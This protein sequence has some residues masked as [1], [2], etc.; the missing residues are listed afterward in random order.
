[1][2][3]MNAN[4]E[5]AAKLVLHAAMELLDAANIIEM[6]HLGNATDNAATAMRSQSARMART[7]EK[8][9]SWAGERRSHGQKE[10]RGRL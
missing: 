10:A 7:A 4:I 6:A 1:M 2:R 8:I 9:S 5:A 3:R